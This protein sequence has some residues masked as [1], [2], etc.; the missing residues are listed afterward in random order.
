[1]SDIERCLGSVVSTIEQCLREAK[2]ADD[3]ARRARKASDAD[4]VLTES[5]DD[6]RIALGEFRAWLHDLEAYEITLRN[7]IVGAR[8]LVERVEAAL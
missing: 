6:R 2:E 8:A 7:A 4:V 5:R 3:R 1:M